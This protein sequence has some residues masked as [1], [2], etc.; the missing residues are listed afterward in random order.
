MNSSFVQTGH[1]VWGDIARNL[2]KTGLTPPRKGFDAG[3]HPPIAPMRLVTPTELGG[4]ASRL[5]GYI[6]QH[7]LAT[8]R[9]F[10]FCYS[11]AFV[12]YLFLEQ[13]ENYLTFNKSSLVNR[14]SAFDVI[15]CYLNQ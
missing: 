14:T 3:D 8:V 7:F 6:A 4:E 10:C 13:N 12:C 5:Y 2:L 1:P 11:N 15:K 9:V